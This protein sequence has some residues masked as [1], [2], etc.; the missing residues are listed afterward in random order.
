MPLSS[1]PLDADLSFFES[2]L[3]SQ[4]CQRVTANTAFWR[5]ELPFMKSEIH[6]LRFVNSPLHKLIGKVDLTSSHTVAV[7]GHSRRHI[8]LL[9]LF[10]QAASVAEDTSIC[11]QNL[12]LVELK[13]CLQAVVQ[14]PP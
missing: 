5:H 10:D 6:C 13:T 4:M 9:P 14:V 12:L 1:V 8:Y 2:F 3:A 11:C 7:K